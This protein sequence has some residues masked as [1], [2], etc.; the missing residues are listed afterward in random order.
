MIPKWLKVGIACYVWDKGNQLFTVERIENDR[1]LLT[2]QGWES[3]TKLHRGG[4]WYK[5]YVGE[6]PVCG[7]NTSYRERVYGEKPKDPKDKYIQL[8]PSY[9]Y[10]GCL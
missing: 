3:L 2:N 10:D 5:M 7:R 6:C 9:C 4:Y 8:S 1:A